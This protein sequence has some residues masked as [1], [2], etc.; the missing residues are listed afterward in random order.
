M[1]T[2]AD[3]GPEFE[4][5]DP[6]AVILRP[7]ADPLGPPP[8]RFEAIRRSA[9]RRRMVRTLAGV[10]VTCAVAVLVAVPLQQAATGDKP[11]SPTVPLAPPPVSD[12]PSA[13]ERPIPAPSASPVESLPTPSAETDRPADAATDGHDDPA[14]EAAPT[15]RSPVTDAPGTGAAVAPSVIP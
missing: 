5:D 4:P 13:T 14:A 1:I 15:P 7:T 12:S 10:G 9:A 6:L 8:G 11:A 2:H 3:E